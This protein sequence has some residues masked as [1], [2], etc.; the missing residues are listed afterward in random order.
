MKDGL[1]VRTELS[2][3]DWGEGGVAA[4]NSSLLIANASIEDEGEYTC[5]SWNRGGI[6]MRVTTVV[7]GVGM[8]ELHLAMMS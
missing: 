3:E 4:A 1:E 7:V 6:T 5:I 8:F 2:G